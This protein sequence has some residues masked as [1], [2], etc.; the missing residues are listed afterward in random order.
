M[1]GRFSFGQSRARPWFK[2]VVAATWFLAV[3]GITGYSELHES[4]PGPLGT[5][6]YALPAGSVLHLDA[7]LPTLLCFVHPQCPCTA[8]TMEQIDRILSACPGKVKF[9]A[10]FLAPCSQSNT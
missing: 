10:E 5:S 2:A 4:R 3:A 6:V 1:S 8:A 9:V 7:G